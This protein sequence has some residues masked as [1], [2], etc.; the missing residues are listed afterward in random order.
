TS[1]WADNR[2]A[3]NIECT[4]TLCD[5]NCGFLLTNSDV[6]YANQAFSNG[7]NTI[8]NNKKN[9]V[10][11]RIVCYWG[12]W[13]VYRPGDGAFDVEDIDPNLCTHIVYTFVGINAKGKV[14]LLD[15]WNDID[16]GAIK[17][18]NALREQNPSLKTMVA[19][20]GWN[21]GS[22]KYSKVM[23]ND[24]TRGI[25]VDNVV[26]FVKKYGFD[27]FD[28]DWEYPTQRGGSPGDKDAF[29]KLL[30]ELRPKFDAN[31]FLLS[32]AVSAGV[33]KIDA[34][35][36]VPQLV[37]N[38]DFINVMTYDLHGD[39]DSAT[40]E[41]APMYPGNEDIENGETKLNV[42]S[43]INIFNKHFVSSILIVAKI[44]NKRKVK[45]QG[46]PL[47]CTYF[48]LYVTGKR[49][50]IEPTVQFIVYERLKKVSICTSPYLY[51]SSSCHCD[52]IEAMNDFL[53]NTL[54]HVFWN[55]LNS[56]Y[57]ALPKDYAINY[58]I[59][60]GAPASKLNLGM[61]TYGRSFTL[62]SSS[63]HGIGAPS[64]GP[65]QGGP[66]TEE[67][68]DLGYNELCINLDQWTVVWNDKQEVPYAYKG[69]Q[70][71][72]YDNVESFKIK[73]QYILD[74][75]IGGAMIWSIDTDDY[76]GKC[77]QGKYPL[78]NTIKS[79]LSGQSSGTEPSNPTPTEPSTGDTD[80]PTKP[81]QPPTQPPTK[82][83]TTTT[84]TTPPPLTEGCPKEGYI[85]DPNN[86]QIFYYCQNVNGEYSFSQ[87]SC[88]DGTLFDTTINACNYADAVQC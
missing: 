58:W 1:K 14:V 47:E 73:S 53:P 69:N 61:G 76:R 78:I 82:P 48:Q 64:T 57:D 27:G 28:I 41:N 36:D 67:A 43:I 3:T 30:S 68:G 13:S 45:L 8:R 63:D 86:C 15:T 65:G 32:A 33:D 55:A 31:G 77:N 79:V 9:S 25:F 81:T 4:L 54:E 59:Q 19:I 7:K 80:T 24:T 38:L 5:L 40:G 49:L 6:Y 72:G 2:Q 62:Q 70:W 16:L 23:N 12:S 85:R 75:G 42:V 34:A 50:K 21:E 51:A 83:P 88:P 87:F 17:R 44:I 10:L 52:D 18:F 46:G 39:W 29:S 60:K 84:T 35:Y 74:H 11:V 20:G 56:L 66:Y 37:K 26:N 71:V 22:K